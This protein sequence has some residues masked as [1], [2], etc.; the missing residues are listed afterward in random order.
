MPIGIKWTGMEEGWDF[1]V[2]QRARVPGGGRVAA[3]IRMRL[4]ALRSEGARVVWS[5]SGA[6]RGRERRGVVKRMG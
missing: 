3:G 6:R 1:G 4:Q 2:T 5:C